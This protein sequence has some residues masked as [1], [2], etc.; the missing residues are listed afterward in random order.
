MDIPDE[1][2]MEADEDKLQQIF[3]NLL[4]NGINYTLDGGKVKIKVLTIQRENDTEKVVFTVSDTG[5]GIPKKDLPR[6]FERFYRVDKGRSRNSG[7]TGLG[8]SIVKHLVDLHHGIL[9]VESELGLG[10]TFTV[11]L[12]LLQQEE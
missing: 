6:I 5:I 2:F 8:L 11:E 12:P 9:S 3:L 10:T 4:S 7:G 1:L